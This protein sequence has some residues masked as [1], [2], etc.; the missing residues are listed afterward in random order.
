MIDPQFLFVIFQ[1]ENFKFTT[2][3]LRILSLSDYPHNLVKNLRQMKNNDFC[4]R[5]NRMY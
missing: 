5:I 1:I 2:S 3:N 4:Y